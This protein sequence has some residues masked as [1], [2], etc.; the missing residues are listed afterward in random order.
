MWSTKSQFQ[1]H[2]GNK[3]PVEQQNNVKIVFV[4]FA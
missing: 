4:C 2:L 3:I 1:N